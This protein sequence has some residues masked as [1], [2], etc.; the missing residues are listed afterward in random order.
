MPTN[1]SY[2]KKIAAAALALSAAT[3]GAER[4][5]R[6]A[7]PP[8]A[9]EGRDGLAPEANA[10]LS[11]GQAREVGIG[12]AIDVAALVESQDTESTTADATDEDEPAVD[13]FSA[14]RSLEE[15]A[16]KKDKRRKK[17]GKGKNGRRGKSGKGGKKYGKYGKGSKRG[18]RSK[19][20]KAQFIYYRDDGEIPFSVD[21]FRTSALR[22]LTE[23]PF[24]S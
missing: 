18:K 7:L 6:E 21:A 10:L 23:D 17:R 15:R 1:S 11:S 4:Q 8:S 19:R 12:G 2:W 3:V 9:V 5:P 14:V 16:L 13:A 22:S 24:E 20:S